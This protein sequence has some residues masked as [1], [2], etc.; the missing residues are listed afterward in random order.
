MREHKTTHMVCFGV[1]NVQGSSSTLTN[2]AAERPYVGVPPKHS[3]S[4]VVKDQGTKKIVDQQI[5]NLPF[6]C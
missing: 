4:H 6:L 3:E 2:F 1:A 5:R